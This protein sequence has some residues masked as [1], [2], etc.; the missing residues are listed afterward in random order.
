MNMSSEQSMEVSTFNEE[1]QAGLSSLADITEDTDFEG[2]GQPEQTQ[3]PTQ[4]NDEGPEENK[5]KRDEDPLAPQ[6]QQEA[7]ATLKT[8]GLDIREFETEF[9]ANG[10][11]SE[12]SYEKLV[13]AGIPRTMVDSY[14]RGQ[15][16][17]AEKT[18][19]EVHA[20]AGGSEGY[21]S[22]VEWAR[23]N[24]SAQEIEAFDHVMAGGNKE[25]IILAVTG[26]VS[27]W[28]NA[29][30]SAPKRMV[31]GRVSPT[32][33]GGGF[34]SAEEMIRA[35]NDPRYKKG[36]AAYVRSVENKIARMRG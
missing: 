17:L 11:L 9:M 35:I 1:N 14:I 32:R 28:K 19:S 7:E 12:E 23:D 2:S 33:G 6:S 18:I 4:Q 31:K 36:D 10:E 29:A 26:V 21:A 25:L 20:I 22:M 15:E 34:E 30:G 24:L 27:R 8:A 13:K 3:E 16:A 5:D